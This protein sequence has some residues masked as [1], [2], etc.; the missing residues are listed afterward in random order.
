M[1]SENEN[2][3]QISFMIYF[4]VYQ[5]FS[6]KLINNHFA[7]DEAHLTFFILTFSIACCLAFFLDEPHRDKVQVLF[8]LDE[9]PVGCSIGVCTD[10]QWDRKQASLADCDILLRFSGTDCRNFIA[11]SLPFIV[12]VKIVLQN[13]KS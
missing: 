1:A 12:G 4:T 5:F 11:S 9:R 10:A 7:I 8:V 6:T 13:N 2:L 3:F